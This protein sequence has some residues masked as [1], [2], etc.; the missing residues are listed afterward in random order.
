MQHLWL[1]PA[2]PLAGFLANGLF[3]RRA[4][5]SVINLI[6][7]GS[8]ALSLAWVLKTLLALG[9]CLP[10]FRRKKR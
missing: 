2:F 3:G 5:K 6:A 4:P 7:V 9:A 8:V 1:I 10:V